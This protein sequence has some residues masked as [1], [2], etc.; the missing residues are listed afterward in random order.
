MFIMKILGISTSPR[1]GQTTDQLVQAALDGAAGVETEFVSLAGRNI[2]PCVACLGCVD[3]NVCVIKDGMEEL[4][5][6]IIEADAFIIGGANYFN[7]LNGLG[8]CFLERWYQF[9]HREARGIAGKLGVALGVGGGDGKRVV[10]DIQTCFQYNQIE[11]V[12]GVSAQ[13]IA[14][15]F[16]CGYGENCN[17]GAVHAMFGEGAKITDENTPSLAKQPDVLAAAKAA[18]AKLAEQLQARA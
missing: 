2:N 1:S 8:R 7:S 5:P 10:S 3:D 18:G 9:R 14:S 17:V 15:C 13:G 16:T 11:C 4:R 6:K 12:A